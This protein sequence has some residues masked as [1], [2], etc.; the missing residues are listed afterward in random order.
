MWRMAEGAGLEAWNCR[1][2]TG[3][4]G[5]CYAVGI[6][7]EKNLHVDGRAVPFPVLLELLKR[8]GF[9]VDVPIRLK[10]I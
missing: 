1:N 10:G 2:A 3:D 8:A 7:D 4:A 9:M 5:D 6:Y